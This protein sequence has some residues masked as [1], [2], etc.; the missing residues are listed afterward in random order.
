[1]PYV[2]GAAERQVDRRL[3]RRRVLG[4]A[5]VPAAL[6]TSVSNVMFD[7]VAAAEAEYIGITL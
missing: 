1:M 3:R 2:K 7:R 5:L 4:G 6:Q